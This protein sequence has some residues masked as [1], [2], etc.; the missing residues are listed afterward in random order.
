MKILAMER[1]TPGARAEDFLPHLKE[2]A[3]CLWG[4]VQAG[5]V[6]ETYFRA[7]QHTAILVLE[8]PS[9]E[10]ARVLLSRLPLVSAGLIGF[11]LIPLIPYDG[12]SRLFSK[13]TP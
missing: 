10:E 7:D 12:F 5:L 4:L 9:V 3:S 13:E 11:E 6:R 2:E 1:E 8:V